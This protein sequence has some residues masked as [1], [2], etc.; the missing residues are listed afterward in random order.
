[1]T[2]ET[3]NINKFNYYWTIMYYNQKIWKFCDNYSSYSLRGLRWSAMFSDSAGDGCPRGIWDRESFN[4]GHRKASTAARGGYCARGGCCRRCC[5]RWRERLRTRSDHQWRERLQRSCCR[6]ASGD[7]LSVA[8]MYKSGG[9]LD[10]RSSGRRGRCWW[11]PANARR[12]NTTQRA[13]FGKSLKWNGFYVL[14]ILVHIR[15]G[16]YEE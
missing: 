1:M 15:E 12:L 5:R 3:N 7:V 10:R 11:V 13:A 14:Y 9:C 4:W 6:R 8:W 16:K 2:G